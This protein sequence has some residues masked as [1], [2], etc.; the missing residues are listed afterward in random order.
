MHIAP[1]WMRTD[2]QVA[3]LPRAVAA[4]PSHETENQH[5]Q[6][7][8]AVITC[9]Y[10]PRHATDCCAVAQIG[11][12]LV[13][14]A[15]DNTNNALALAFGVLIVTLIIA[16]SL[17]IMAPLNYNMLLMHQMMQRRG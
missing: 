7:R 6:G 17:W 4:R 2:R 3:Q 1:R 12:H 5:D 13:F 14:T 8:D 15:P 10:G 9:S 11:M 16:G